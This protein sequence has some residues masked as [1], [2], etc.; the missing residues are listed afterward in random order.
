MSAPDVTCT[1]D[2]SLKEYPQAYQTPLQKVMCCV[3]ILFSAMM[4]LHRRDGGGAW[5]S[6]G[7]SDYPAVELR[8]ERRTGIL[9]CQL[10][11]ANGNV[12]AVG[13]LMNLIGE[14]APLLPNA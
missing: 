3:H 1:R 10:E 13:K 8:N 9:F 6:A 5:C 11:C 2:F 4:S 14:M 7:R 12:R